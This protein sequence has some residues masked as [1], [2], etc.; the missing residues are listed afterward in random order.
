MEK[1]LAKL[2]EIWAVITGT[3]EKLDK[4]VAAEERLKSLDADLSTAKQ[5]ISTLTTELETTKASLTSKDGEIQALQ[6][7]VE[8]EKQRANETIASQGLAPEQVPAG[9]TGSG[10]PKA[11]AWQRYQSLLATD[12]KAAGEFYAANADA[13]LSNRPK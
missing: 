10:E 3:S 11:N 5:T 13:V 8:T 12:P 4:I 1:I 9:S 6:A 2:G 7:S